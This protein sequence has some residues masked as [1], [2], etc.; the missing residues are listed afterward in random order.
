ML[1]FSDGE[2]NMQNKKWKN[3]NKLTGKCYSNMIGAEKDGSCWE[4]AFE[5]LKEI[6]LEER[7][8][9]PGFASQLEMVDEETDY[10][11]DVQGWMEDC[12]DEIDMREEYELLLKMCDDLLSI[13]SWPDYTG[14]DIKFIKY[15]ALHSLGRNDEAVRYCKEWICEEPENIVAAAAGVYAF[16]NMKEFND[17]EKLVNQFIFD[18]SE[19]SDENDIMFTAASKLYEAAGKK[20]E[21][22]QIDKA[23]KEYEERLEQYFSYADFD[24]EDMEFDLD[25]LDDYL[26]F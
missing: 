15:S 14:S 26:P 12:L 25:F 1:T 9:N 11:Y 23:M 17:A 10:E 7:K 19:C 4:K 24:D 22:K 18:K 5:L 6:I 20:K 3:F 21:K 13:F 2:N 16:I 8:V